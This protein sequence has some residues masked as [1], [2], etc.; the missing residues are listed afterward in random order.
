MM[1]LGVYVARAALARIDFSAICAGAEEGREVVR[2]PAAAGRNPGSKIALPRLRCERYHAPAA[3]VENNLH[4]PG[5]GCSLK[6]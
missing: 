4:D 6:L 3:S 5:E 2:A 1:E